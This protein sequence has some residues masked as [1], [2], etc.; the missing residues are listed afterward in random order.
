MT[1]SK[2]YSWLRRSVMIRVATVFASLTLASGMLAVPMASATAPSAPRVTAWSAP[3]IVDTSRS[4]FTSVSCTQPG[5]CEAVGWVEIGST[6]EGLVVS[7][8]N[9]KWGP[10][11]GIANRG[12]L[13]SVSCVQ[14][15]TGATRCVAV[16]DTSGVAY[17]IDSSQH[18]APVSIASW[19]SS[20]YPTAVSCYYDSDLT[21]LATADLGGM[22]AIGLDSGGTWTTQQVG[23]SSGDFETVGCNP[24]GSCFVGGQ[25]S[26]SPTIVPVTISSGTATAGT[27]SSLTDNATQ[28]TI[29]AGVVTAITCYGYTQCRAV[30]LDG[31][32]QSVP[33]MTL[34]ISN[35]TIGNAT[36]ATSSLASSTRPNGLS[37]QYDGSCVLVGMQESPQVAEVGTISSDGAI[38]L[39]Y[40]PSAAHASAWWG[41]SCS[42][43]ASCVAVGFGG[44]SPA[45]A[46]FA[47]QEPLISTPVTSAAPGQVGTPYMQSVAI[48]GGGGN[49]HYQVVAGSLPSGLSL[50]ATTGIISGT[51]KR[52]QSRKVSI[53]ATDVGPPTQVVTL[54]L[55]IVVTSQPQLHWSKQNLLATASLGFHNESVDTLSCWSPG[56]CA[57]LGSTYNNNDP[58][59]VRVTNGRSGTPVLFKQSGST[60][61]GG[62][63]GLSCTSANSCVAVGHVWTGNNPAIIVTM[64]NGIWGQPLELTGEGGGLQGTGNGLQSVSCSSPG[65]CTAVGIGADNNAMAIDEVHG[66]WGTPRSISGIQDN[67]DGS[68]FNSVNCWASE[69]CVATGETFANSGAVILGVERPSSNGGQ[70]TITTLGSGL[71][72]DAGGNAVSCTGTFCVMVGAS[73]AL[74]KPGVTAVFTH[75]HWGSLHAIGTN[76]FQPTA[77]SCIS[78]SSCVAVGSDAANESSYSLK[79]V[80]GWGSTIEIPTLKNASMSP[81]LTSVAC[82]RKTG[83]LAGGTSSDQYGNVTQP[84]FV[85]TGIHK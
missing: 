57:A 78:M 5:T 36:V 82:D 71:G 19:S 3:K 83:C 13:S 23:S 51:P 17:S 6:Y 66:K 45:Q 84:F 28:T 33:T 2:P 53:R 76:G 39:A 61:D 31:S 85:H 46:S 40:S 55:K 4:D 32:G 35:G 80:H 38:T 52:P 81:Y 50:N 63:Y 10:A 48:S 7:E 74:A 49:D 29:S 64:T 30:G 62:I 9:G 22:V 59:F 25:I 44:S 14:T 16:G 72:A 37:C 69:H 20:S 11:V 60:I 1:S 65:N 12:S 58:F 47:A 24:S 8:A 70:W 67:A 43:D 77:V 75:G 18:N 34:V 68:S 41:V 15:Q 54:R 79:T 21:C 42:Y 26:G 73:H 56:N 27:P